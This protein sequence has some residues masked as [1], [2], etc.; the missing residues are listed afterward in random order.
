[1]IEY[2]LGGAAAVGTG[3]ATTAKSVSGKHKQKVY[4]KYTEKYIKNNPDK[5]PYSAE[6]NEE[7]EDG[8]KKAKTLDIIKSTAI[9]VFVS[10]AVGIGV[11]V[12]V[13]AIKSLLNSDDN[14]DATET[15]DEEE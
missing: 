5:D 6:N 7:F 14:D 4:E 3:V 1:M 2:I 9:S 11:G 8:L 12:G 10:T 15:E 13:A